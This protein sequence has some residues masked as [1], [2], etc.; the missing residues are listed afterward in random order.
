MGGV[1]QEGQLL[2]IRRAS[3]RAL[4]FVS[5]TGSAGSLFLWSPFLLSGSLV[6]LLRPGP[7]I[8]MGP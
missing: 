2:Q 1:W 3:K 6:L 4:Q 5:P 8:P 7:P